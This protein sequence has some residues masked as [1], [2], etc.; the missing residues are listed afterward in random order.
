MQKFQPIDLRSV[1]N[2]RPLAGFTTGRVRFWGIPFDLIDPAANAGL[3]QLQLGQAA[4]ASAQVMIKLP[5]PV[6]AGGLVVAH[7]TDVEDPTAQVG[8]RLATYTLHLAN[9]ERLSWP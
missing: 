4:G 2:G 7:C 8:E 5:Q 1:A 9:G 6:A 3:G